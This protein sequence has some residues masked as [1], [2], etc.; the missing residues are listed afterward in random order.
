MTV[1]KSK[2]RPDLARYQELV[3]L[4]WDVRDA[5]AQAEDRDQMNY[6]QGKKDG[7]RIAIALIAP[8][9]Q[10][11]RSW[12]L[13]QESSNNGYATEKEQLR[14]LARDAYRIFDM[15]EHDHVPNYSLEAEDWLEWAKRIGV[16]RD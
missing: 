1:A 6:W 16:T 15:L 5:H 13:Q 8:N 10:A 4:F 14:A 11:Q 2:I 3:R 9:E 7:I 12:E